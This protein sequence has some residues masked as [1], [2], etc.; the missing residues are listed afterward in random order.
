M[1]MAKVEQTAHEKGFTPQAWTDKMA[2]AFTEMWKALNIKYSDLFE[3]RNQD[4]KKL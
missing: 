4:T 1:N 2:P 3:Q